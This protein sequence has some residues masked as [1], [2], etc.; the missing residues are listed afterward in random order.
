VLSKK[1]QNIDNFLIFIPATKFLSQPSTPKPRAVAPGKAGD[2]PA[3]DPRLLPPTHAD[4][5]WSLGQSLDMHV[6]LSTSPNG[7]VFSSQ[8]TS[9]WRENQDKDLPK[10]VWQNLTFGNFKESRVVDL[11][12]KFPEVSNTLHIG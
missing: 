6:F 7:D 10:F 1:L 4:L 11:N 2:P 12:V 8:W 9:G 5:A 3:I